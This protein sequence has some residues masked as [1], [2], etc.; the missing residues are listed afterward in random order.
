MIYEKSEMKG[1]RGKPPRTNPPRRGR[2][3]RKKRP[4]RVPD[5]KIDLDRLV[6][7]PEYRDRVRRRLK[8]LG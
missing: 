3:P 1:G 6:W 4:S 2:G 5:L 8:R 7:D